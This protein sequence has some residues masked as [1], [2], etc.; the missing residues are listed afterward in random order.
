MCFSLAMQVLPL[1][2]STAV[3]YATP[4]RMGQLFAGNAKE[5]ARR[6]LPD[7]LQVGHHG[8]A[9]HLASFLQQP[10]NGLLHHVVVILQKSIG[11]AQSLLCIHAPPGSEDQ[12][13][14]RRTTV[15]TI[16]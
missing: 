4:R 15:P 2:A 14:S 5:E 12:G 3:E 7:T 6:P 9:S 11:Q 16:L 13:D 10:A 8:L 1:V